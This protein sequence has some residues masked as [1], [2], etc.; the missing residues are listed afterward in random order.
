MANDKMRGSQSIAS[1]TRQIGPKAFRPCTEQ[2]YN[3]SKNLGMVRQA[4][5]RRSR[6]R[7]RGLIAPAT[8]ATNA[9]KLVR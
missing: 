6:G 3:R 5:L 8:S 4:A 2:G 7:A 1:F 9:V